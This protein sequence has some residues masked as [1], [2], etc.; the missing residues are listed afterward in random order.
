MRDLMGKSHGNIGAALNADSG[1]V[2][3][4]DNV[5][6]DYQSDYDYEYDYDDEEDEP[7]DEEDDDPPH[8]DVFIIRRVN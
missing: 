1:I 8:E 7:E 5:R 6:Y 4:I 3:K 2:E